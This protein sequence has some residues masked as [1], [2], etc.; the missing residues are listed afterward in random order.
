[1]QLSKDS[2]EKIL[3]SLSIM[4]PNMASE[5]LEQLLKKQLDACTWPSYDPVLLADEDATI[6]VQ[7]NGKLRAN[8]VVKR[9][10]SKED[11][12]IAAEEAITKWLED[13]KEVKVVF[14]PDKLIN[15]VVR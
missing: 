13:K 11:V 12:Q 8:I 7:V 2:V 6:V 4:A 1:M 14:V 15:F 9:G 3:V 10:S 5:L